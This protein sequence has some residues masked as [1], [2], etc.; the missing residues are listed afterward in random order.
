MYNSLYY[1]CTCIITQITLS[2]LYNVRVFLH[3]NPKRTGRL[4]AYKMRLEHM[5]CSVD[6]W[7]NV[8]KNIVFGSHVN[9][10]E[11]IHDYNESIHFLGMNELITEYTLTTCISP[12]VISH[13]CHTHNA[14]TCR[15]FP[16][17]RNTWRISRGK[18]IDYFQWI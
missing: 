3:L 7:K 6:E 4:S 14:L 17:L 8:L 2:T 13:S 15:Q 12:S 5:S 9:S 18:L 11:Y 16:N 1:N 10:H